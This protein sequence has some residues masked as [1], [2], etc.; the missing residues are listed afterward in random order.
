[1][2]PTSAHPKGRGKGEYTTEEE[3]MTSNIISGSEAYDTDQ[4]LSPSKQE[5]FDK[6]FEEVSDDLDEMQEN[7]DMLDQFDN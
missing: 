6:E 1:M 2:R 4:H 3:Y 5:A 7:Q